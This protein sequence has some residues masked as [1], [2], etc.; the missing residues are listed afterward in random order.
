MIDFKPFKHIVK[1]L[2][3]HIYH[4]EFMQFLHKSA[5]LIL[6]KIDY[7]NQKCLNLIFFIVNVETIRFNKSI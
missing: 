3:K 4:I 2:F 7:F 5:F 1:T 6:R